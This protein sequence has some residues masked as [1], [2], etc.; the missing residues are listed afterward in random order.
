METTVVRVFTHSAALCRSWRNF[1]FFFFFFFLRC[2]TL[3]R[4][5]CEWGGVRA[6]YLMLCRS[7]SV[8]VVSVVDLAGFFFTASDLKHFHS[9]SVS[10]AAADTTVL[11]SG[12]IAICSTRP[13]CPV[14]ETNSVFFSESGCTALR[15]YVCVVVGCGDPPPHHPGQTPPLGQTPSLPGLIPPHMT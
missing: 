15:S 11:P 12:D 10:S 6:G 4:A 3:L 7:D 5:L 1:Q 13:V 14:S 2:A 8:P 9:L